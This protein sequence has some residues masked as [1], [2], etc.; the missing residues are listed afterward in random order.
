MRRRHFGLRRCV[1]DVQGS[2]EPGYSDGTAMT[3]RDATNS[4]E[5][6]HATDSFKSLQQQY[7]QSQSQSW[8]VAAGRSSSG[9]PPAGDAQTIEHPRPGN[10]STEP[11]WPTD[12]ECG[13]RFE[14]VLSNDNDNDNDYENKKLSYR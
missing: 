5:R 7:D 10:V 6:R 3:S 2:G 12:G 13:R 1:S 8:L 4:D 11:E 9:T 14:F